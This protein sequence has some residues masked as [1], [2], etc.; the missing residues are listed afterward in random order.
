[1]TFGNKAALIA[2]AWMLGAILIGILDGCVGP[3]P[4]PVSNACGWDQII[5]PIPT[6]SIETLR[7]IDAHNKALRLACPDIG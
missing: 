1:M 2:G 4:A 3:A 7:Q 6:D 5:R